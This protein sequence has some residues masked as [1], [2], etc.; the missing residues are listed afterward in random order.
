MSPI[1]PLFIRISEEA[2]A[3]TALAEECLTERLLAVHIRDKEV[4]WRIGRRMCVMDIF[5]SVH[6]F[7]MTVSTWEIS[8]WIF[9]TITTQRELSERNSLVQRKVKESASAV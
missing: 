2:D 6:K 3:L 9:N 4:L 8:E 1:T 7:A 5:S